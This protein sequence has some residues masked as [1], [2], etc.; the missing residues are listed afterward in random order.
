ML[1]GQRT[2]DLGPTAVTTGDFA[3]CGPVTPE[4]LEVNLRSATEPALD[5]TD[6]EAAVLIES[7]QTHLAAASG[8]LPALFLPACGA[9]CDVFWWARR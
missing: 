5:S 2:K 7:G 3:D 9:L 8:D 1:S 4:S 6:D